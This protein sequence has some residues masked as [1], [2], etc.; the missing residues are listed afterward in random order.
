VGKYIWMANVTGIGIPVSIHHPFPFG[1]V[2][3]SSTHVLGLQMLHLGENIVTISHLVFLN[4]LFVLSKIKSLNEN[5][6]RPDV[7]EGL[8]PMSSAI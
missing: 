3:M 2:C 1:G 4:Y 6:V 8:S 5:S 7:L